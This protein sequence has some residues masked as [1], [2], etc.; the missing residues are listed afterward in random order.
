MLASNPIKQA[1]SRKL[2]PPWF[3]HLSHARDPSGQD[4]GGSR[5]GL[6]AGDRLQAMCFA[7]LRRQIVIW[8]LRNILPGREISELIYIIIEIIDIEKGEKKTRDNHV[9]NG[10]TKHIWWIYSSIQ[11]LNSAKLSQHH[12]SLGIRHEE[13][14]YILYKGSIYIF[15]ILKKMTAVFGKNDCHKSHQAICFLNASWNN[16]RIRRQLFPWNWAMT[17]YTYCRNKPQKRKIIGLFNFLEGFQIWVDVWIGS[18]QLLLHWMQVSAAVRFLRALTWNLLNTN[19]PSFFRSSIH[20]SWGSRS[21][22]L[23]CRLHKL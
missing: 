17:A 19:A 21:Y 22:I 9:T 1:A 15:V 20:L 14:E 10:F 23:P 4:S 6:L 11:I 3:S 16:L 5:C 7:D 2:E 13:I 12:K 8:R 18:S